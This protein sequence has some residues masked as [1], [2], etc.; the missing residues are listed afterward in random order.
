MNETAKPGLWRRM[1][2]DDGRDELAQQLVDSESRCVELSQ[3]RDEA[4]AEVAKLSS[5]RAELQHKLGGLLKRNRGLGE[6]VERVKERARIAKAAKARLESELTAARAE[7]KTARERAASALKAQQQTQLEQRNQEKRRAEE[8]RKAKDELGRARDQL[9]EA[10]EQGKAADAERVDLQAACTKLQSERSKIQAE[11]SKLQA[12]TNRLREAS[13]RLEKERDLA[14]A[15]SHWLG[16][17]TSEHFARRFDDP[18]LAWRAWV[19]GAAQAPPL[20]AVQAL[21]DGSDASWWSAIE[22]A[23]PSD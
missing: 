17:S 10:Q 18:A 13:K 12:E 19:E 2:G 23:L 1:M 8:L 22:A 21:L 11:R 14:V 16:R 7:A 3:E 5:E 4:Q 15:V 9:R 6:D 20:D